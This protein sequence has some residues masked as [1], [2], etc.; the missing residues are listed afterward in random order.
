MPG[1]GLNEIS[2]LCIFGH[3]SASYALDATNWP[4]VQVRRDK[5]RL[6]GSL[7]ARLTNPACCRVVEFSDTAPTLGGPPFVFVKGRV[8]SQCHVR[9]ST[10]TH[11][12]CRPLKRIRED[13]NECHGRT[14]KK[15]RSD[16][17]TMSR[18][19]LPGEIF[20]FLLVNSGGTSPRYDKVY[21]GMVHRVKELNECKCHRSPFH[22][23]PR[24]L[25]HK[26]WLE[27][28]YRLC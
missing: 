10:E 1:K 9:L 5:R 4:P 25:K 14:S 2:D 16:P 27:K 26:R 17:R 11:A 3:H 20:H 7:L 18:E 28:V 13:S 19:D 15:L 12:K 21:C 24:I 6:D 8:F 22:T 23:G